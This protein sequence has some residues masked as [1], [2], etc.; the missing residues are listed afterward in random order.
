MIRLFSLALL[1]AGLVA[2]SENGP[3]PDSPRYTA[4]GVASI[5][6]NEY[7]LR[8]E[9][10]TRTMQLGDCSSATAAYRGNGIWK[11]G[12]YGFDEQTGKVMIT[13]Q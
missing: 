12:N 5:V 6:Q 10:G 11:C 7:R 2:C 9:T 3:R 1:A 8:A 4:A 13:G